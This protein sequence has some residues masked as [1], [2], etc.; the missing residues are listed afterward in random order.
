[1]TIS[2]S[3]PRQA[4][5][6]APVNADSV[7]APSAETSLVLKNALL[8]GSSLLATWAVA[9]IVR[10]Y[11]PRHLGPAAYGVYNFTDNLAATG[12]LFLGFG[13]EMYIQKE[14]PVR[15]HH[16]SDFFV[17][18]M[19]TRLVASLLVFASLLLI[20]RAGHRSIEAQE[21]VL[22]FGVAQMW[23]MTNVTLAALIHSSRRVGRLSALNVA[24]KLL[25]GVGVGAAIWFDTGLRG[26]AV[27]FLV[28]EFSRMVGLLR[29]AR[30][31]CHLEYRLDWAATKR[32]LASSSPYFLN[33]VAI[34]VYAKIDV[35]IMAFV[36][37]DAEIGFY[38]SA[39]NFAGLSM[40]LAPVIGWV[41]MPQMSR[42][43]TRGEAELMQLVRRSMEMI[44]AT[45]IPVSLLMGIGADVWV[46]F[47]FGPA[48][49]PAT[50]A[51]RILA[52]MFVF[53]YVAMITAL[54]LN[55]LG[56]AW[57]VTMVS[58]VA[59]VLNG[60]AN[61]VIIPI[62]ERQ[63]GAG[64]AGIGAASASLLGEV[65]VTIAFLVSLGPKVFDARSTSSVL[66][67]LAACV[68]VV[69][70][71]RLLVPLGPWRLAVDFVLYV[72]LVV[73]TGAVQIGEVRG[74]LR[75]L[76]DGVRNRRMQS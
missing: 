27:A 37:S 26:L 1:M 18:L 43:A 44:L 53:T 9:L 31:Q 14:I 46:R 19:L 58:S 7:Y 2:P 65:L 60:F 28:S 17:G 20:V 52:P 42:A 48:F 62:A 32:V 41:L 69:L 8:L 11:L 35:N 49:A 68:V 70:A 71:D 24:T 12:F 73:I 29:V 55:L 50:N 3:E 72:G 45:A 21:T 56:K 66:K 36:T 34:A 4:Q 57:R 25:W 16:A 15:P 13:T 22:L 39:A 76:L 75:A 61:I 6:D 5:P 47:M 59:C 33:T 38:G 64:G 10:L 51:L 54:A 30:Q 74:L 40:L 63:F 67:S 23:S